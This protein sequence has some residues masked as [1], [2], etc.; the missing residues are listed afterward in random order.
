M[1]LFRKKKRKITQEESHIIELMRQQMQGYMTYDE[2]DKKL[3]DIK[4]DDTRRR[5]WNNMTTLQKVRVLRRAALR[6][7]RGNGKK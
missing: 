6:K 1:R 4:K 7:E 3:E 5:I 2:L